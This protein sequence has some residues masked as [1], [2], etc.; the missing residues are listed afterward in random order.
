MPLNVQASKSVFGFFVN[1]LCDNFHCGRY[2][3]NKILFKLEA[4]LFWDVNEKKKY[5][6]EVEKL[7]TYWNIDNILQ[8]SFQ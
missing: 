7:Q 8:E 6:N 4:F 3:I 2:K 5:A 1:L